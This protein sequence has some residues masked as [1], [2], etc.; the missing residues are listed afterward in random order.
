MVSVERMVTVYANTDRVL[1]YE[2]QHVATLKHTSYSVKRLQPAMCICTYVHARKSPL[3]YSVT[4]P[5]PT[6]R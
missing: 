6:G 3:S 1:K 5:N 4:L 2:Q